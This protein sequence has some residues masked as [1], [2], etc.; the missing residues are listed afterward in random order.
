MVKTLAYV[1]CFRIANI[2]F[3]LYKDTTSGYIH[4]LLDVF[5]QLS[6]VFWPKTSI[7][8]AQIHLLFSHLVV[9]ETIVASLSSTYSISQ[10]P[11]CPSRRYNQQSKYSSIHVHQYIVHQ[12]I[13][14]LNP[15][16]TTQS[17]IPTHDRRTSVHLCLCSVK[18]LLSEVLVICTYSLVVVKKKTHTVFFFSPARSCWLAKAAVTYLLSREQKDYTGRSTRLVFSSVN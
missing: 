15:Q 13:V 16:A 18:M 2:L 5:P 8:Y 4:L 10:H 7:H 6:S 12:Y 1:P 9:L 17:N 14:H 3:R 11:N